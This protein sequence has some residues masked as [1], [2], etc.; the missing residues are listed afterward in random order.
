M[1]LNKKIKALTEQRG[2]I[3]CDYWSSMADE[4]NGLKVEYS[5]TKDDR[6]HPNGEGYAVMESLVKPCIDKAL[7]D[8]DLIDGDGQLDDFGKVE[9]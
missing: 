9:L 6:V 1:E 2:Y 4:Q 3:Y 5:W 7:Y 8:P